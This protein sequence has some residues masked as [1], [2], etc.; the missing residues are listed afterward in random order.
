MEFNE[1]T[2]TPLPSFTNTLITIDIALHN[3]RDYSKYIKY[4]KLTETHS[5]FLVFSAFERNSGRI[6]VSF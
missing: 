6:S 5:R 4:R 1:N 3:Q 2:V